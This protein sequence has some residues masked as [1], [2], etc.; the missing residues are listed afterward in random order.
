M[1]IYV[2]LRAVNSVLIIHSFP[3]LLKCNLMPRQSGHIANFWECFQFEVNGQN[4][5][6]LF[7]HRNISI[8]SEWC[9]IRSSV[10]A[11]ATI[12][13]GDSQKVIWG[14]AWRN[15][16]R[17]GG[18]RIWGPLRKR[19]PSAK[20]AHKVYSK[21]ANCLKNSTMSVKRAHFSKYRVPLGPYQEI[22]FMGPGGGTG[23]PPPGF[24]SPVWGHLS[25]PTV[26]CE[27]FWLRRDRDVRVV[28]LCFSHQDASIHMQYDL[29]GSPR[30]L[31]L[32]TNFSLDLSRLCYTC[33]DASERGKHDGVKIIALSSQ[34]R[35]LSSKNGFAQKCRF[36][37]FVTSDA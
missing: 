15:E 5:N 35:K 14:Q 13:I 26:F 9:W 2:F 31:D 34:T 32:R 4:F 25:S 10:M 6:Y 24:S 23:P 33:L 19:A 8:H 3:N 29:L 22:K 7:P 30:D 1:E 12:F 27:Y 37:P 18:T 21:I 20:R 36:W 16:Y 28:S 17:G 11:Q